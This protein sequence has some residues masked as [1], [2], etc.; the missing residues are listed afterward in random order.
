MDRH[1]TERVSEALRE[2]LA[3]LIGYELADA[4]L[5]GITVG[6]VHVTPDMR[7]AHVSI[8]MSADSGE[9]DVAMEALEGARNY[10]RR[11]LAA[12]MR[13]FRVP[14]LHFIRETPGG[15]ADR[16]EVLLAR[17]RKGRKK[18]SESSKNSS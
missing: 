14:E 1:R 12:R 6:E 11:Q 2:E 16:I 5:Y 18:V 7:H 17:V 4:R 10:L 9:G 8:L 3:E 13:L 15:P